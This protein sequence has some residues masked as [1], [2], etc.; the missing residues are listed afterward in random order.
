MLVIG[1]AAAATVALAGVASTLAQLHSWSDPVFNVVQIGLAVADLT[2]GTLILVLAA[3]YGKHRVAPGGHTPLAPLLVAGITYLGL[4]YGDIYYATWF[5]YSPLNSAMAAILLGVGYGGMGL[6]LLLAALLRLGP[7]YRLLVAGTA[8]V[9]VGVVQGVFDGVNLRSSV[10]AVLS[11]AEA[12]AFFI[13]AGVLLGSALLV[14]SRRAPSANRPAAPQ[15]LL[16]DRAHGL[17]ADDSTP[18][19]PTPPGW[20]PPGWLPPDAPPIP[21]SHVS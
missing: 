18:A 7:V 14:P 20:L 1:G 10:A 5:G 15:W 17:P 3:R 8:L 9:V 21:P 11:V 19:P 12:A 4:L 2:L 16:L 6:A 13:I